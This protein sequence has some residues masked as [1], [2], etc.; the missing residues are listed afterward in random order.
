MEG[1]PEEEEMRGGGI[2]RGPQ[3][4]PGQG[5][6]EVGRGHCWDVCGVEGAGQGGRRPG[7][8]LVVRGEWRVLGLFIS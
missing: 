4:P 6:G 2:W 3:A 1:E 5:E 8:L 7:L